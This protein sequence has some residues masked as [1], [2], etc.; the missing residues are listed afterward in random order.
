MDMTKASVKTALGVSTDAELARFFGITRA[1]V[2]LW[3]DDK[4]IP[5]LRQYELHA[6]RSDLFVVVLK[7]E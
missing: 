3:A 7:D 5:P 6:R 1:A 2:N 4:P